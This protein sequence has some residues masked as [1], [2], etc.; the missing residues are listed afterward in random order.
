MIYLLVDLKIVLALYPKCG[1]IWS[2]FRLILRG[3]LSQGG[4]LTWTGVLTWTGASIKSWSVIYGGA[5]N[6]AGALTRAGATEEIR[7]SNSYEIHN[8]K[9]NIVK[10]F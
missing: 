10:L 1:E 2:K 4:G 7:Y 6:R 8:L 9:D 3:H 5:L